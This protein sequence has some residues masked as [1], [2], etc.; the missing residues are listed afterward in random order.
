MATLAELKAKGYEPTDETQN[1]SN[2]TV[3]DEDGLGLSEGFVK[4]EQNGEELWVSDAA[5]AASKKISV[6]RTTP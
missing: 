4:W 3:T 2:D 5:Y 6:P 1:M